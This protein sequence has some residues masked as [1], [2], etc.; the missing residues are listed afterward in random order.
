AEPAPIQQLA[1]SPAAVQSPGGQAAPMTAAA[2]GTAADVSTG[3]AVEVRH[4]GTAQARIAANDP[5][6]AAVEMKAFIVGWGGVEGPVATKAPDT[7]SATE[8]KMAQAYALLTSKPPDTV[9]AAKLIGDIK[10]GLL[11]F[12]QAPVR[13]TIFD[14]AIILL[15]E[16]FEALLVVAA[17]LA[18]LKKSGNEAKRGWIWSGSAAGLGLSVVIAVVVNVAFAAAAGSSR[19]LL[20]GVT[21]L[22]AAGM[23]IWM[24]FWLHSKANIS[25]WNRYVS[26]SAGRALATNS[27]ISLASIAFLAVLREGAETVLF[28]VGIAP[29]ISSRDLFAGLAAGATAL[30]LVAVLMLVVGVRIPIRPFF[31]ATSALIFFLAFKFVGFGV[32]SLQVSGR[33]TAHTAGIPAI[34]FLG[35]FPTWETTVMQLALLCGVAAALVLTRHKA[36]PSADREQPG[37]MATEAGGI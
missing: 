13:Y 12:A 25:A 36:E 22:V 17:L 27:L 31:L 6:G 8:N 32:H 5:A 24:M 35:I 19:E 14:A 9:Q 28:Y 20:E 15:R 23:L 16:G 11:P 18:F 7:Y 30:A 1:T 10:T 29:A 3:M 26:Q 4:L 37:A 21:G 34:G 33:V 2:P